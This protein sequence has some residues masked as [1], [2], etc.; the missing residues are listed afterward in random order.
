MPP[1][2]ASPARG[3]TCDRDAVVHQHPPMM[4]HLKPIERVLAICGMP[5]SVGSCQI[6]R[7]AVCSPLAVNEHYGENH[8][9]HR[10][11]RL[12]ENDGRWRTV[13]PS[14]GRPHPV[15]CGICGGT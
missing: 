5:T 7:M 6:D 11:E 3:V 12:R 4:D 1:M 14:P 15:L 2:T 10:E 8:E 9:R 13:V